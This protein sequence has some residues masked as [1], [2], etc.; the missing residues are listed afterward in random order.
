LVPRHEK[1]VSAQTAKSARSNAQVLWDALKVAASGGLFGAGFSILDNASTG[2][3][4]FA[5]DMPIIV[6]STLAMGAMSIISH[7]LIRYLDGEFERQV[8]VQKIKAQAETLLRRLAISDDSLSKDPVER[9]LIE[10]A[11][12]DMHRE[13]DAA[14]ANVRET[15]AQS[16]MVGRLLAEI[17][18]QARRANLNLVMGVFT[19]A[20]AIFVLVW[21]AATAP[22][23]PSMTP[24]TYWGAFAS[25][26]SLSTATSFFAY[27]FLAT[28]R[29]NLNEI[30]YFQNELTNI[31]S[32]LFAVEACEPGK[33]DS[34]RLAILKM[35]AATERNFTLKRGETTVDLA[36]KRLDREEID[37]MLA[38]N[39]AILGMAR[40]LTDSTGRSKNN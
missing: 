23:L 31:Q 34:T 3:R 5:L 26:L 1:A 10:L 32:R 6:I 8:R 16:P 33:G 15:P 37:A 18:N 19:A 24:M 9:E 27:F 20:V 2:K 22:P 35:I 14:A 39:Q 17:D 29:R 40:Q 12:R 13:A 25:K 11:I 7:F 21:L 4:L 36:H 28:Y 38:A 30:R